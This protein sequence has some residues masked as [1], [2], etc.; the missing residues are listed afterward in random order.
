MTHKYKIG[1]TVRILWDR[2]D[3]VKIS[4][5]I[6]TGEVKDYRTA[7]NGTV[8]VKLYNFY[9]RDKHH[10]LHFSIANIRPL[11]EVVK[12]GDTL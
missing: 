7:R 5:Y 3:Y 2:T 8:L 1:E 10:T 6:D 4:G 9:K 11:E 12:D